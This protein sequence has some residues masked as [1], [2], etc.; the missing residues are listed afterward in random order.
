MHVLIASLGVRV[1]C[2]ENPFFPGGNP[3]VVNHA[4]IAQPTD[5]LAITRTNDIQ[6]SIQGIVHL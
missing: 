4:V 3:L 5:R 1:H 2:D 6:T